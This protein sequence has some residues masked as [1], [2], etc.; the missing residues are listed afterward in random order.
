MSIVYI[1]LVMTF[2][3]QQEV[4]LVHVVWHT[5]VQLLLQEHTLTVTECACV[6]VY[7]HTKWT[8]SGSVH[9]S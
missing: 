7:T 9:K 6:C 1:T 3:S 4:C 2:K 8:V 5:V